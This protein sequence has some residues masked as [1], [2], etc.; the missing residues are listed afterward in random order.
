[1]GVCGCGLVGWWGWM[2]GGA[3]CRMASCSTMA[4]GCAVH[5]HVVCKRGLVWA[6]CS[7]PW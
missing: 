3:S 7:F 1:M 6:L 4:L 2:A 5:L